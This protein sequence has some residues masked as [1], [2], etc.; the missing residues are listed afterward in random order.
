[1]TQSYFQSHSDNDLSAEMPSRQ[2]IQEK[3]DS[4]LAKEGDYTEVAKKSRQVEWKQSFLFESVKLL[5]TLLTFPQDSQLHP[6]STSQRRSERV[7]RPVI[8][9]S[10]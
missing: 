2:T 8:N 3:I 5:E 9:I 6:P 7:Q 1:M 10:S 4:N